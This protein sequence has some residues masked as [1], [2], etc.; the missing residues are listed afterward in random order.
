MKKAPVRKSQV[1]KKPAPARARP[2]FKAAAAPPRFPPICEAAMDGKLAQVKK[3]LKAGANIEEPDSDA[4][5]PL[6]L[7]VRYDHPK[8]ALELIARG[9]NVCAT[10]RDGGTAMIWAATNDLVEV[11]RRLIEKGAKP[12]IATGNVGTGPVSDEFM[13]MLAETEAARRAQAEAKKQACADAFNQALNNS[14]TLQR[15]I[16]IMKPLVFKMPASR[17]SQR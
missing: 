4:A 8:V 10:E 13:A 7:A 5:T 1:K 6:I 3:L 12:E 16:V 17:A 2:A 14:V 9:A 15:K 11:G